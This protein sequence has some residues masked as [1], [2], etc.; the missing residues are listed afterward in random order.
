MFIIEQP[1][2]L[3]E[4]VSYLVAECNYGGHVTDEWDQRTLSTV[5]TDF[6]N[7]RVITDDNY[8]FS[9]AG[10]LYGLPAQYEYRHYI[11]HIQV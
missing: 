9:T 1:E 11:Q 10:K 7:I 2:V 4:A 5:L 6:V 8:V 3:L